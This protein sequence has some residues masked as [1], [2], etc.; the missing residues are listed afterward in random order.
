MKKFKNDT[1]IAESDMKELVDIVGLSA[2]FLIK[3]LV[4]QNNT[5]WVFFSKQEL[6]DYKQSGEEFT[7]YNFKK[8]IDQFEAC[9]SW[10][11]VISQQ[12]PIWC[13]H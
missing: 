3:S 9:A 11:C 5:V 10:T 8:F 12:A 4:T 13:G 7:D 2:A 6:L 1:N